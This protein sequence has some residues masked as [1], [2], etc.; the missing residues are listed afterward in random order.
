MQAQSVL[1]RVRDM[2]HDPDGDVWPDQDLMPWLNE[3]VRAIAEK[4]PHLFNREVAI[5]LAAG[6]FQQ[7]VPATIARLYWLVSSSTGRALRPST[8]RMLDSFMPNWRNDAA[9]SDIKTYV[10]E[11]ETS[12]TFLVWPKLTVPADVIAVACVLPDEI[13]SFDDDLPVPDFYADALPDYIL[14]CLYRSDGELADP[15][16]ADQH[17]ARFVA[18]V[19]GTSADDQTKGGGNGGA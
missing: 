14:S 1:D 12:R 9:E 8:T 17:L 15:V 18:R 11:G 3:G 7:E 10:L 4:A 2:L 19:T 6:S 5:E 13:D 16:R